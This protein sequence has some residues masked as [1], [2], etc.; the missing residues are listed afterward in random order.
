MQCILVLLSLL[1]RLEDVDGTSFI[2]LFLKSELRVAITA[3]WID[4]IS[5]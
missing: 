2:D 4:H 5:G 1:E 3:S